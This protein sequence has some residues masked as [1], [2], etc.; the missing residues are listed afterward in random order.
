MERL[1]KTEMDQLLV[2]ALRNLVENTGHSKFTERIMNRPNDPTAVRFI[3]WEFYMMNGFEPLESPSE[4]PT[5]ANYTL[6]IVDCWGSKITI[7]N[8][9][10]QEKILDCY[11]DTEYGWS[12]PG[13]GSR[14]TLQD[15]RDILKRVL[16]EAKD[17]SFPMNTD[18]EDYWE[19]EA[20]KNI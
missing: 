6:S 7:T 20:Y 5:P 12:T 14:N 15:T 16:T 10:T 8:A 1:Y 17:G 19:N 2:E 13:A 9:D 11:W 4:Y 3:T 18:E